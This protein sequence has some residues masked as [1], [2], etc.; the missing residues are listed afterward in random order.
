MQVIR[1]ISRLVRMTSIIALAF[2]LALIRA[3]LPH[4]RA[5]LSTSPPDIWIAVVEKVPCA[6]AQSDDLMTAIMYV[7]TKGLRV[8]AFLLCASDAK[9]IFRHGAAPFAIGVAALNG[10]PIPVDEIEVSST[11]LKALASWVK[12]LSI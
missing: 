2:I 12:I 7:F 11:C 5:R 1:T 6:V 10:L 3:Q 9:R 8:T 4:R